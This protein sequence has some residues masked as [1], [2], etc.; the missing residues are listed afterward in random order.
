MSSHKQHHC[1][2]RPRTMTLSRSSIVPLSLGCGE[3]EMLDHTFF[4][5]RRSSSFQ[6]L[7]LTHSHQDISRQALV[8]KLGN[9]STLRCCADFDKCYKVGKYCSPSHRSLRL[10]LRFLT[11]LVCCDG[12]RVSLFTRTLAGNVS[13][14]C[15]LLFRFARFVL[16]PFALQR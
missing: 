6:P 9:N 7:I 11:C 10:N 15:C 1:S 5:F 8:D 16:V 14:R 13:C 3:F 12:I 4:F 2:V